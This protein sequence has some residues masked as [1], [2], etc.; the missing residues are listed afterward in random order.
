M[1]SSNKEMTIKQELVKTTSTP[2]WAYMK[3]LAEKLVKSK[4]EKALSEEDET[5]VVSLQRKAQ[6]AREFLNDFLNEIERRKQVEA[7]VTQL[8]ELIADY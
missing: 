1:D 7:P 5:R 8:S 3:Q 4:E 2:G 6:A